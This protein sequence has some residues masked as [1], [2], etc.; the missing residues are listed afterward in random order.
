MPILTCFAQYSICPVGVITTESIMLMEL[1][2]ATDGFKRLR[3]PAEYLE[4]LDYYVEAFHIISSEV[5][6]LKQFEGNK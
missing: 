5:Q 1:Y 3:T 2:H 6:R 4:Q